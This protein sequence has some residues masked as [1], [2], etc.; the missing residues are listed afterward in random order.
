MNAATPA[1]TLTELLE[2]GAARTPQA[3][4]LEDG[5]GRRLTYAELNAAAARVACKLHAMGVRKGDRVGICM[6]KSMHSVVS[7]FGILKARAAY[8]PVDYSA[9]ADRNRFIFA[10]CRSRVIC[11]DEPRAAALSTGGTCPAPLL[12]F[13]GESTDARPHPDLS[14]LPAD[15]RSPDPATTDD[16]AYI[17]YTSGSTGVPKGVMHSHASALSFVHWCTDTFKPVA[18]DRFSSHAPFHFD[19]SIHDLYVPFTVGAAIVLVEDAPGK[20][21]TKLG[22]FI[23]DRK[24]SIWYSVPSILALIAEY[25][26]LNQHDCS[27]LRIVHFAGEVFPIQKFHVL[28]RCWPTKTYFNLYGP[29]ETNVCTYFRVPDAVDDT[30]NIPWPIGKPCENVQWQVVDEFDKPVP[31]GHEGLLLIERSG[32]VMLDY[33]E[34]PEQSARAFHVD[35]AGRRWYRTGDVVKMESDGN[36]TFLGRRDRMVK[37]RGYRIELAEIEAALHRHPQLSEAATIAIPDAEAGVKIIACLAADPAAKPSIVQ[38]K[39]FCAQHLPAYM[40]PDQFRFFEKLPRTS[41]DKLDYQGMIRTVIA[42]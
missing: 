39:Q 10:N 22:A 36:F 4:A 25:G 15:W 5:A 28:R 23:A 38:L 37:R 29:T 13:P 40:N 12:T 26:K 16:L 11:A 33:W 27:A 19:L 42:P 41:T 18:S 21:P 20:D 14:A 7:L 8:V 1:A 31:D 6:P 30:R 35:A 9:P 32:P 34:L 17:L 3:V 24:I 2:S